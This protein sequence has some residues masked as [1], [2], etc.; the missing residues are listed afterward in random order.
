MTFNIQLKCKKKPLRE[1]DSNATYVRGS[2]FPL[3]CLYCLN[4]PTPNMNSA[5]K[6]CFCR[7]LSS[8]MSHLWSCRLLLLQCHILVLFNSFG[9]LCRSTVYLSVCVLT[10][11]KTL[12]CVSTSAGSPPARIMTRKFRCQILSF[13][14]ALCLLQ[15]AKPRD[16][17]EGDFEL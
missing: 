6:Y 7:Q 4:L 16:P 17:P 13:N 2:I 15:H 11:A 10:N 1:A 3:L 9:A 5:Q 14:L 8:S 12:Y